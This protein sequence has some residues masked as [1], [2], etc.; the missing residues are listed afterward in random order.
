MTAKPFATRLLDASAMGLSGLCLVHCLALPVA[1][2]ALPMLGAWAHAEWVHAAFLA[3]AVPVSAFALLRSGGWRA[4]RIATLAVAGL[5][6]LAAGVM[7]W[8]RETW[9]T[10]LTVT[11]GLLLASAHVLNWRRVGHSHHH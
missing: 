5:M 10:A 4:P 1:A 7:G 9:E 6:L 8:P 2:A 11:G 3:A